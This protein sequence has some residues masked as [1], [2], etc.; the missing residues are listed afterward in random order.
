MTMIIRILLLL[1]LLVLAYEV[2]KFFGLGSV[3]LGS[4]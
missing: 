2:I 1:E 3:E 4:T